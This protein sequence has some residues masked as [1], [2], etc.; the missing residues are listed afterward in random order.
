[1]LRDGPR[2]ARFS[3]DALLLARLTEAGPAEGVVDLG[4]GSGV[5]ALMMA[6]R[7]R[8]G[9]LC[10]IELQPALAALARENAASSGLTDRLE[11]ILMD[12]REIPRRLAAETF[13]VAVAN[14][15]HVKAGCGRPAPAAG[16]ALARHEIAATAG[17]FLAAA[18]HL[19]RPGGR[20]AVVYPPARLEEVLSEARSRGL[21]AQTLT[22]I[23]NRPSAPPWL[24]HIECRKGGPE[25][26]PRLAP[27]VVLR[28]DAGRPTGAYRALFAR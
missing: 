3:L 2:G 28:D 1:M 17:D 20:C 11:V 9:R 12:L 13:D 22:P 26:P 27:A 6:W 25:R 15:P 16:R 8:G 18:A 23:R 5:V 19:L 4:C 14:P 10:G 24:W 7:G 21:S